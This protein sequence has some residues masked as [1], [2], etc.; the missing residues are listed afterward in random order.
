MVKQ[1]VENAEWKQIYLFILTSDRV[2]G[3]KSTLKLLKEFISIMFFA[4]TA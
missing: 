1:L 4:A 3:R 2:H